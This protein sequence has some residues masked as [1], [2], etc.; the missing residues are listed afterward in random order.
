M[1]LVCVSF[2]F[3]DGLGGPEMVMIFLIV[4]LLF[5]GQKLP[6]FARGIGKTMREFK[7]AASGVED[8]FRRALEEDERNRYKNTPPPPPAVSA[9]PGGSPA[10]TSTDAS[11]AAHDPYSGA[12]DYAEDPY[13]DVGGPVAPAS[14]PATPA[15]P[16]TTTASAPSTTNPTSAT[17]A[18]N[19]AAEPAPST[20]P[21][22]K[23]PETP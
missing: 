10:G 14:N 18:N 3:I 6:E 20:P 21:P 12:G 22:E 11:T 2:A 9:L 5:G 13:S 23:R 7:K 17:E 1:D 19:A 8:E 16:A 4:L 15:T